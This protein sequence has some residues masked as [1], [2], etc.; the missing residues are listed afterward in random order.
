MIP[1]GLPILLP[2]PSYACLNSRPG[3]GTGV[4]SC[5]P[6][7]SLGVRVHC[8]AVEVSACATCTLV[9]LCVHA[10]MGLWGRGGEMWTVREGYVTDP[11][12]P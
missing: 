5:I 12:H 4:E 3:A 6:A 11:P 8:C 10:S 9:E 1:G 2:T 7:G